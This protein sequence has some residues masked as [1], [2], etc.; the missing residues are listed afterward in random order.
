MQHTINNDI[1]ET[2]C[3]G[4]PLLL[5]QQ[6]LKQKTNKNKLKLDGLEKKFCLNSTIE[7]F[8]L[9]I[10]YKEYVTFTV[11]EMLRCTLILRKYQSFY[12]LIKIATKQDI[13]D[14]YKYKNSITK[15]TNTT[16]LVAMAV[17]QGF[18]GGVKKLVKL[19]A[20]LNQT[21]I[22]NHNEE[23][24]LIMY[25]VNNRNFHFETSKR[26][27]CIMRTL[28]FLLTKLPANYSNNQGQTALMIACRS[29]NLQFV[30]ELLL[31]GADTNIRDCH[32]KTAFDYLTDGV[33]NFS[34][35]DSKKDEI[36]ILLE[37][38]SF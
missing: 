15:T 18:I 38:N 27:K 33:P 5:H 4:T 26:R 31:F 24:N 10:K 23:C 13:N 9:L 20:K 21:T 14:Q 37:T 12:L 36:L 28:M 17:I 8:K 30:Q 25:L 29:C 34:V 16:N 32:N 7:H 19:G 1:C 35:I 6:L 2:I 3:F 11:S 22:N